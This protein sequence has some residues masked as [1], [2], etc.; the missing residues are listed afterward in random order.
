MGAAGLPSRV[1]AARLRQ[2][3]DYAGDGVAPGQIPAD[4]MLRRPAVPAHPAGRDA[5]RRRRQAD[6]PLAVADHA[7]RR[8]R[9]ARSQ[10][11]LPAARSGRRA[12]DVVSFAKT[13]S[14]RGISITAPFKVS[15]MPFVDEIEP[16]AR[17]VG[18]INTHRRP[19][20]AAG[21]APTPTSRASSRRCRIAFHCAACARTI[22]GGGGAARAVAVALADSGAD[23]TIS[24]RR[25]DAAGEVAELVGGRTGVFPPPSGTWD[26]LVNATSAQAA[27]P[28]ARA[29]WG[30][31]R[32]TDEW[33]TTSSTSPKRPTLLERCACR[34]LRHDRRARDARRAGGASVRALD[35]AA[36]AR[37]AFLRRPHDRCI[38]ANG[39]KQLAYPDAYFM[40]Q[41]T[42]EEFVELTRRGTFVP[43]VKEIIADLLTPVSAF[44][45][46][47]EHS[48]YAFLFESVEGGE[49]VARYSFLGKDP[50]LV[51]RSRQG[52]TT[53]DRSG[54]TTDVTRRIRHRPP[55]ADD[56]VSI[57]VRARACR[58]SRAA[59]SASSATTP[60]R[61]SSRRCS[62][63]GR[64]AG[65]R[66]G[67]PTRTRPVSCSSIPSWPS[68]TS[69]I[70]S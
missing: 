65:S 40:K 55:P 58:A 22:L 46:I 7:Q 50:F 67:P 48:D 6:R 61:A 59:P 8:L 31:R 66:A 36:A 13:L 42:F 63:H 14:L 52:K 19:Q 18:A 25:G 4:R 15:L 20:T 35:R 27:C 56:R 70:G 21:S 54:V 33:S 60:R 23:V 43:V 45:K 16:I 34:G 29:R 49:Q 37:R 47:A 24:A 62:R 57:A 68:I 38:S 2:P 44:L 30:A 26:L 69:S 5:L 53:I 3:M 64:S 10:R 51:L 17:R 39:R 32:S 11:R 12:A 28:A 1:L 41:T 9:R